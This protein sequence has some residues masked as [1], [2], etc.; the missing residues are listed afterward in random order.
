M[1]LVRTLKLNNQMC[2]HLFIVSIYVYIKGG[3]TPKEAAILC[4]QGIHSNSVNIEST[5]GLV[6]SP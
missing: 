6:I 1:I 4:Q 2:F 5:P 3:S